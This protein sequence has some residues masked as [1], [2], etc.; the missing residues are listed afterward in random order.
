[1]QTHG[2]QPCRPSNLALPPEP[3]KT[4]E[5]PAGQGGVSE[6]GHAATLIVSEDTP[7]TSLP[8]APKGYGNKH[9]KIERADVDG[10]AIPDGHRDVDPAVVEALAASMQR[11]GLLSPIL[12]REPVALDCSEPAIL[13]SG[14]HRLE[15]AKSLGW[16]FID[17]HF[18]HITDPAARVREIV[19]NLHRAE[20]TA[21]ERS[22]QSIEVVELYRLLDEEEKAA[23]VGQVSK[24]GRGKKGGKSNAAKQLG[25]TRQ[26]LQRAEKIASIIPEAQAAAVGAGIADNQSGLLKVAEAAPEKQVEA[27]RNVARKRAQSR[28]ERR[29]AR[30]DAPRW[31]TDAEA[32]AA[33]G[34]TREQ[35]VEAVREAA[36]RL[37]ST[38][39]EP[40]DKDDGDGADVE[41][42]PPEE[43]KKNILD[44][45]ERQKAITL[46]YKKVLKS[47]SLNQEMN[48]EVSTALGGLITIL[49]SLQ[50]TLA[51]GRKSRPTVAMADDF[52]DTLAARMRQGES[53]G[54]PDDP[55]EIPPM[56]DRT[57]GAA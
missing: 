42:A 3:W 30:I 35:L 16:D 11:V 14:R 46:A 39:A 4:N 9:L 32:A 12:L 19:E 41:F 43:I 57:R 37:G 55:F 48:N 6:G 24:G 38:V 33:T 18:L 27:V 1:M 26:E 54:A 28:T 23:Q 2:S 20:L 50:R 47:Q 22:N 40:D 13:I 36:D 52:S 8:Q 15:A 7:P 44:S 49:Q 34:K 17:C 10:I 5:N 29:Q 31:R 53:T 45:I 56:L 25:I 21:L 51:S